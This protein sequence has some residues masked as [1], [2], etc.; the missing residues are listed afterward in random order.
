MFATPEKEML[1]A[2]EMNFISITESTF[3]ECAAEYGLD[4]AGY[5][6]QAVFFDYDNDGDLDCYVLNHNIS[7]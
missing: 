1:T 4:D 6:T 2:D 3:T 7:L 5:S